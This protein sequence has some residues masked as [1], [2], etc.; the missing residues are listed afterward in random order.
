M[1]NVPLQ[2][3][4]QGLFAASTSGTMSG[5]TSAIQ[6]GSKLILNLHFGAAVSGITI[7]D[8]STQ[9]GA[10]NT[11]TQVLVSTQT[12]AVYYQ[13]Y[14]D[15]TRQIL[16]TDTITVAW[17]TSAAHGKTLVEVPN[18]AA[19][20]AEHTMTAVSTSTAMDSGSATAAAETGCFVIG[21][22]TGSTAQTTTVGNDGQGNTLTQLASANGAAKSVI[23]GYKADEATAAAFKATGTW[24]ASLNWAAGVSV[25][26]PGGSLK[27]KTLAATQA[28]A[29]AIGR[30]T[31]KTFIP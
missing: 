4:L 30:Q 24:G 7:S 8:N 23:A 22:G 25:W 6:V 16:T 26:T 2:T 9:A 14:C 28:Q 29:A 21:G 17:T 27:T 10:A 5:F 3:K 15:V 13:F 1:S 11:W 31:N 19:G 12:G 20:N 18:L